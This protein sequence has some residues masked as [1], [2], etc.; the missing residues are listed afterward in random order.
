MQKTVVVLRSTVPPGTTELVHQALSPAKV[1]YAPEFLREGSALTDFLSPDRIVVGA[2]DEA[3][4]EH[5][6]MLFRSLSKP[7]VIT[8]WRDA[9]LI[10]GCSNAFLALKVTFANQVANLCDGVGANA[11]EVL[12][13]VGADNRIGSRFLEP[14]IGFGGPCFEKD[15]KSLNFISKQH[16]TGNDLFS[17]VLHVNEMQPKRIVAMLKDELG[18]IAGRRIG[19][20]GLSFKAGT[21]DTR[22]SIAVR[23]V[24]DLLAAGRPRRRLRSRSRRRRR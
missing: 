16:G 2:D 9:E 7:V 11:L 23:I 3:V 24:E 6:L 8:N 5:Y 1:V 13:G 15:V 10:K 21:D 12:R 14:G 4:A 20:W 17:A 22:D 19:V 18:P